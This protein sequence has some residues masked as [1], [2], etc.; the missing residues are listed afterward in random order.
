M[1]SRKGRV[2]GHCGKEEA[3]AGK[4]GPPCGTWGTGV[5]VLHRDTLLGATKRFHDGISVEINHAAS[6]FD[7]GMDNNVRPEALHKPGDDWDDKE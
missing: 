1:G 2:D 3:A 5:D 6:I 4:A 7:K